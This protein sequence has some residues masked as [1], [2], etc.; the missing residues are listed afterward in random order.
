MQRKKYRLQ[1]L[2]FKPKVK[3]TNPSCKPKASSIKLKA[4]NPSRKRKMQKPQAKRIASGFCYVVLYYSLK[5]TFTETLVS[6]INKFS[7]LGLAP[8]GILYVQLSTLE[9]AS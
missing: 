1:A 9:V 2:S 3:A 5:L 7:A 8:A 6:S 4:L